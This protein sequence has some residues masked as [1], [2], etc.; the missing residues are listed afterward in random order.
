MLGAERCEAEPRTAALTGTATSAAGEDGGAVLRELRA[1]AVRLHI[2]YVLGSQRNAPDAVLRL[3]RGEF[4][5]FRPLA[6]HVPN[7]VIVEVCPVGAEQFSQPCA[8]LDGRPDQRRV[9]LLCL[10]PAQRQVPGLHPRIREGEAEQAAQ[11]SQQR[12]VPAGERGSATSSRLPLRQV[13]EQRAG[14]DPSRRAQAPRTRREQPSQPDRPLPTLSYRAAFA[15]DYETAR[16]FLPAKA[17]RT[18]SRSNPKSAGSENANGEARDVSIFLGD[19]RPTLSP[20]FR[21]THSR[22]G[23]KLRASP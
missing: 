3:R 2:A 14:R 18:M 12:G 22:S 13:R 9:L 6:L 4:A 19:A 21:G 7:V 11:G 15:T 10:G 8:C 1:E 16:A 5:V 20:G 23:K 17:N